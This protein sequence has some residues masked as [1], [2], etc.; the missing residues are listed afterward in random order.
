MAL[1]RQTQTSPYLIL[2]PTVTVSLW[3]DTYRFLQALLSLSKGL[4]WHWHGDSC[5]K[6]WNKMSKYC[7]S[8][9]RGIELGVQRKSSIPSSASDLCRA[10]AAALICACR[11]RNPNTWSENEIFSI[12]K[13]PGC[14]HTTMPLLWQM[15]NT[16][17]L[18]LLSKRKKLQPVPSFHKWTRHVVTKM[19]QPYCKSKA[20][21]WQSSLCWNPNSP[22]K[23]TTSCFLEEMNR[24][25]LTKMQQ[26][27]WNFFLK[28]LHTAVATNS[29]ETLMFPSAWKTR[30]KL[31]LETLASLWKWPRHNNQD[32]AAIVEEKKRKKQ[33]SYSSHHSLRRT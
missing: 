26:L 14:S 9:G 31:R 18:F 7:L 22:R 6:K 29:L 33:T 1:P 21:L 32:E 23:F 24:I 15:V 12:R 19:Q 5:K 30:K 2:N 11:N 16:K 8:E 4:Q 28:R 25:Q 20:F 10:L 17:E 27:Y 3:F 13:N